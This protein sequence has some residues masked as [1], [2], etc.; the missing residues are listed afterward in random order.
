[1]NAPPIIARKPPIPGRIDPKFAIAM[2]KSSINP[3]VTPDDKLRKVKE[4]HAIGIKHS[5]PA[6]PEPI[7]RPIPILNHQKILYYLKSFLLI[8]NQLNDISLLL[9]QT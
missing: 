2:F 3:P 4:N 1:M 6:Q 7:T 8:S 5:I 9:N